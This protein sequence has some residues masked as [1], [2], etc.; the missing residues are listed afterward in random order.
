[1]AAKLVG[2]SWFGVNL[3][4]LNSQEV[5]QVLASPLINQYSHKISGILIDDLDCACDSIVHEKLISLQSSCLN[6]N[7]FLIFTSSKSI[8]E[9][10]IFF[11]N[12]PQDIE[13]K[14]DDF[15]EEDI[16]EIL[17]AL[18]VTEDYWARYIYIYVI[19]WRAPSISNCN[20]SKYE[21]KQMEY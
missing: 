10:F 4:G 15:S 2:G 17:M 14:V 12:L 9:D 11:A 7:T 19:R 21:K 16:K 1:M 20:D 13:K 6:A 8:D 18:G 3:R 5:C